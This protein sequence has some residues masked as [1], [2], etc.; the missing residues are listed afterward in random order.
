MEF[1]GRNLLVDVTNTILFLSN[2][3]SDNPSMIILVSSD[4]CLRVNLKMVINKIH[5]NAGTKIIYKNDMIIFSTTH[6]Q[7]VTDFISQMIA[8]F[9]SDNFK[10]QL[11]LIK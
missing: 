4:L 6:Y 1:K 7:F 11:Q 10:H 8:I 9:K 5:K 3:I 2:N